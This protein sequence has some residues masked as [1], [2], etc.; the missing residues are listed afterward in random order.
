MAPVG[1]S[2]CYFT[3]I[4]GAFH[5]TGEFAQIRPE[6]IGALDYWVLRGGSQ[7]GGMSLSARCVA[8]NQS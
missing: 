8:R 4:S 7:A 3:S 2:F 6:R 5:G 1:N